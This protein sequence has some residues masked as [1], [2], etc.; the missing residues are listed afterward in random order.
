MCMCAHLRPIR[1]TAL[2][3]LMAAAAACGSK[4][5]AD[6]KSREIARTY[7]PTTGGATSE[8]VQGTGK[9]GGAPIA[10]G[11]Q[12][13]LHDGRRLTV[14]PYRL[15]Q[16]HALFGKVAMSFGLFDRTGKQLETVRSGAVTAQNATFT[17]E[18]TDAVATQ[19][20]DLVI[21]YCAV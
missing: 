3:C 18:L 12:C 15:A 6:A 10:Q 2:A 16:T 9:Q 7:G 4:S 19:V 1:H 14:R 13:R 5:A 17:F 21:W 20:W 8:H 11:W